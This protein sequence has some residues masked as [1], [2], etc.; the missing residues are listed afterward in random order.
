MHQINKILKINVLRKL[1]LNNNPIG[2]LGAKVLQKG[3]VLNNSLEELN[4]SCC[5][6]QC[7][8]IC[9]FNGLVNSMQLQQLDVSGNYICQNITAHLV[10]YL[11]ST[12][13]Q[14]LKIIDSTLECEDFDLVLNILRPC[15]H[16]LLNQSHLHLFNNSS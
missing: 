13:S 9:I 2:E 16:L 15:F 7:G 14:C 5:Q 4:I 12:H 11:S 10:S 1:Y 6:L 3:L 8:V